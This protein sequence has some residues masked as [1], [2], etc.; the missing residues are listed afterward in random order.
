M[1][2]PKILPAY[3]RFL[4][5]FL[6]GLILTATVFLFLYA[7]TFNYYLSQTAYIFTLTVLLLGIIYVVLVF[8]TGNPLAAYIA[9]GSFSV[10]CRGVFEMMIDVL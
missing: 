5:R 4:K 8:R 9:F 10:D 7:L 3:D 6:F 2:L 1:N